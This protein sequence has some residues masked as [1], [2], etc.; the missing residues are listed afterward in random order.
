[1]SN[2]GPLWLT[3]E[4]LISFVALRPAFR[5]MPEKV[6]I[7][8]YLFLTNMQVQAKVLYST[9]FSEILLILVL[10]IL[11]SLS[12]VSAPT[13]PMMMLITSVLSQDKLR[14]SLAYLYRVN[15]KAQD[16]ATRNIYYNLLSTN[17]RQEKRT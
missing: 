1:M 3:F 12:L 15:M 11:E 6:L 17:G 8:L 2:Y 5:K 9:H 7:G 16:S 13:A 4:F 14:K 10:A